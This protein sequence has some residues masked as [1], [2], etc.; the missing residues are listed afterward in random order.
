MFVLFVSVSGRSVG[1]I[2]NTSGEKA[3]QNFWQYKRF[4]CV[5]HFGERLVS[6]FWG[7]VSASAS[8]LSFS[9]SKHLT[10]P[11]TTGAAAA[12]GCLSYY[13]RILTG[14]DSYHE[15]YEPC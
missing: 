14:L 9:S 3:E 13:Y 8:K 1:V 11:Y 12:A 6:F 4:V 7:G 2:R 10:R 15:S 5:G